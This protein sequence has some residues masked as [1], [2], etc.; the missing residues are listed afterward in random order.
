VLGIGI[1]EQTLL[2]AVAALFCVHAFEELL[3]DHAK[4]IQ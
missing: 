3:L 2:K 1:L 4:H